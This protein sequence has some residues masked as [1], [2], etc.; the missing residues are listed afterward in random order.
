MI[1][2]IIPSMNST[3]LIVG[4]LISLA[5]SIVMVCI[6]LIKNRNRILLAQNLQFLLMAFSNLILGGISGFI[7]NIVSILRNFFCLKFT[8]TNRWKVFFVV[9]QTGISIVTMCFSGFHWKEILPILSTVLYT[10]SLGSQDAVF[11][12]KV[13]IVCTAMWVAYDLM[14]LN[15][16]AF[17]FDIL[18]ITTTFISIIRIHQNRQQSEQD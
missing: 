12:K 14:N 11:L 15:I 7:A 6:G 9:L 2:D 8:Y 5:G 16:T 4:N 3:V 1:C 10:C 13:M 18:T 17:V